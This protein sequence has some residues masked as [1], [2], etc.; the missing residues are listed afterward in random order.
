[1]EINRRKWDESVPLHVASPSYDLAGFKRGRSPLHSA[2]MQ[3]VGP[4]RGRSLLH[5]QC[6]FGMD[7][8]S[9]A[10]LG[11]RVTGVDYSGPAIAAARALAL[12]LGIKARFIE[13]NV[14]EAADR[15]RARFD[16][17]YTG[18]GALI[19]L[20]DLTSW[21]ATISRLLKR[22]G[23]FV[24][25]E[26][27]PISDVCAVAP[28]GKRLVLRRDIFQ[29]GPFRYESPG[30]Y[31]SGRTQMRNTVSYEW[32]HPV[33][34]VIDALLMAGLRVDSFVEY[35]YTYWR[36]FPR[37]REGPKGTWHLGR[38]EG[39]IPLMY[40]LRAGKPWSAPTRERPEAGRI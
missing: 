2:E 36:K 11:A 5:L 17:V 30:T 19:W 24:L 28:G 18:K 31:A 12:D 22:G 1:M 40:S 33:S 26:D 27:H 21:A 29:R 25:L 13:S 10:R 34:K 3:L 6:H 20:P 37:M 9:W 35:P 39:S 7:T 14:Y 38:G 16:V 8:L 4:L 32:V 15:V 23:R